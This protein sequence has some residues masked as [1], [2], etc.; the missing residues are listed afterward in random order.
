VTAP[1]DAATPGTPAW[2]RP[3]AGE[4]PWAAVLAALLAV[5]LQL[6]LPTRFTPGHRIVPV[7]E[8]ALIVGLWVVRPRGTRDTSRWRRPAGL[9]LVGMITVTNAWSAV[10]LVR[11]IIAGTQDDPAVLLSS[12]GA[13]WATNVVVFALWYWQFDSGG[14]AARALGQRG[15]PDFSFPQMQNP[16]LAH[17]DWEPRFPDYLYISF[18]NACAFSPTD[19]LPLARWAKMAMLTQSAI[20]LITIALVISRAVG[21]FK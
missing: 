3:T 21:L 16:E 7:L 19:T 18:T 20:S 10:R 13:I 1:Q 8:L 17:P 14:P 2:R 5:A 15:Y 6:A 9:T 4:S 11:Q 12:G